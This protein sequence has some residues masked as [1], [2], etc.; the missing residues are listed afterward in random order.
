MVIR[1]ISS[2]TPEDEDRLAPGVLNALGLLLD[3][4]PLAYNLR[5][6]TGSGRVFQH[7]NAGSDASALEPDRATHLAQ[8]AANLIRPRTLS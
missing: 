4:V 2:L 3:H 6:E 8:V 1:F 5:I 7:A